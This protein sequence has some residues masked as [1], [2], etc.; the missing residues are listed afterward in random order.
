MEEEKPLDFSS[1]VIPAARL[2]K[3]PN[4]VK[5]KYVLKS[6]HHRFSKVILSKEGIS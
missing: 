2:K 1:K 3:T 6:K 5:K 4:K